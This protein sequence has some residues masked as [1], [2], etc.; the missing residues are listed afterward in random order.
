MCS[1]PVVPSPR[2]EDHSRLARQHSGH[3]T[4]PGKTAS[5]VGREH[6]SSG[7]KQNTGSRD[8]NRYYGHANGHLSNLTFM[9]LVANLANT[10]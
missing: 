3:Q 5:L 10:K 2:A 8:R 4:C 7:K 1:R 9:L 6:L